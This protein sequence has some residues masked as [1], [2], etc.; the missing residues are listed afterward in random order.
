MQ[1][2]IPSSGKAS[3]K[4]EPLRLATNMYYDMYNNGDIQKIDQAKELADYL[5]ANLSKFSDHGFLTKSEIVATINILEDCA[6]QSWGDYN[7]EN[8]ER[9]EPYMDNIIDSILIHLKEQE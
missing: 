2:Q 5:S 6:D 8:A 4:Y 1:K 9:L 3:E 7:G